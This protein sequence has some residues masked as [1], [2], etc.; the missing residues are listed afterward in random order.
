MCE[1]T[2]LSMVPIHW[3]RELVR[4]PAAGLETLVPGYPKCERWNEV[5][6]IV[7]YVSVTIYAWWENR[8]KVKGVP[9]TCGARQPRRATPNT[10]RAT[11][12]L[13]LQVRFPCIPPEGAA[14]FHIQR[15]QQVQQT[16]PEVSTSAPRDPLAC[17]QH[18]NHCCS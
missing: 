10:V 18:P 6:A 12:H 16:Y 13:P 5:A 4:V 3:R 7:D 8:M 11:G 9:E 15:L 17:L 14:N 1:L 2:P